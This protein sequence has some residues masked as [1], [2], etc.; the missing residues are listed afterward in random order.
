MKEALE[1]YEEKGFLGQI[2][3]SQKITDWDAINRRAD[4][5][6]GNVSSPPPFTQR[7]S[8][9]TPLTGFHISNLP[10]VEFNVDNY[11]GSAYWEATKFM[12]RVQHVS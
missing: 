10:D 4:T 12:D 5:T 8:G 7:T 6:N 3:A 11:L 2:G 9:Q 1:K